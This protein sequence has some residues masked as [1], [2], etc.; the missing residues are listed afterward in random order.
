[1]P[2][3]TIKGLMQN[4]E[5]VVQQDDVTMMAVRYVPQPAV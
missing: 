3:G 4:V 5:G 1:M 2:N